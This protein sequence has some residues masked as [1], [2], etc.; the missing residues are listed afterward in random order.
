MNG[1]PEPP[2]NSN[3]GG[4]GWI[5][6]GKKPEVLRTLY[7]DFSA[8]IDHLFPDQVA[9]LTDHE[10]AEL[11]A[12]GLW[13]DWTLPPQPGEFGDERR[14]GGRP[15]QQREHRPRPRRSRET[16]AQPVATAHQA[17]DAIKKLTN[18]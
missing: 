16:S 6:E 3:T 2:V 14:R 9:T 4:V 12:R 11:E 10:I 13:F 8:G 15:A 18:A 1:E 7:M 5:I 17:L